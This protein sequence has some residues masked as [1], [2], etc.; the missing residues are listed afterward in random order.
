MAATTGLT[1]I[2]PLACA[3]ALAQELEAQGLTADYK[4]PYETQD[5]ATA[6]AAVSLVLAG[7]GPAPEIASC[8]RSFT[9]RFAGTRSRRDGLPAALIDFDLARPRPAW[10]TC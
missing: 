8:V 9:S 4:P 10:S 6:M 5:R 1:Y 3:S 2:G 7:T